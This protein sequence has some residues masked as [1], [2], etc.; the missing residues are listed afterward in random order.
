[1]SPGFILVVQETVKLSSSRSEFSAEKS[2]K[3]LVPGEV[4][5][6]GA[7]VVIDTQGGLRV[8]KWSLVQVTVGLVVVVVVRERAGVQV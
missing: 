4:R 5:L 7:W 3:A 2:F 6:K 8:K 1:M